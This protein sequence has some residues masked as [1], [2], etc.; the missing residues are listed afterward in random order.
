MANG[1]ITLTVGLSGTTSTAGDSVASFSESKL[2]SSI[3]I[4]YDRFLT[5]DNAAARTALVVSATAAGNAIPALNGLIVFNMG[6]V[7]LTLGLLDDAVK[8]SYV[9]IPAGGFF[10]M[11]GAT[12]D[13]DDDSGAVVGTLTNIDTVTLQAASATCVC[14]VIAY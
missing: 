4:Y 11:N 9:S 10:I 12:L 7:A 13:A 1:D 8:S 3:S 2:T 6:A 14:R 5:I